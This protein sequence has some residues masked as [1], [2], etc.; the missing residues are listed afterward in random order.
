[1]PGAGGVRLLC[2][3]RRLKPPNHGQAEC[4]AQRLQDRSLQNKD[5]RTKQASQ[6]T[7]GRPG[8]GRRPAGSGQQFRAWAG[9]EDALTPASLGLARPPVRQASGN[10]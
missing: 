2:G 6:M 5:I 4:R 3:P 10:G 7:D 8:A 9:T 1:M